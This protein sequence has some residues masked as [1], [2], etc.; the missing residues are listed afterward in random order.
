M[1]IR[2]WQALRHSLLPSGGSAR[3][4][5][6]AAWPRARTAGGF[7]SKAVW[8]R[9][10]RFSFTG[11]ARWA[12]LGKA[13]AGVGLSRYQLTTPNNSS[14]PT[15]LRGFVEVSRSAYRPGSRLL[16]CGAA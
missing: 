15:P 6:F 16:R 12:N 3:R 14:K 4:A 13:K 7:G 5:R 10:E 9:P 2:M 1:R 8:L 11:Q